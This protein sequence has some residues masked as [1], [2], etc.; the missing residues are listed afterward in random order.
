MGGRVPSI[1]VYNDRGEKIGNASSPTTSIAVAGQWIDINVEQEIKFQQPTFL[2]VDAVDGD[3]PS[4]TWVGHD[5]FNWDKEKITKTTTNTVTTIKMYMPE[6][7]NQADSGGFSVPADTSSLCRAPAMTFGRYSGNNS[8]F[9]SP[10]SRLRPTVF[11]TVFEVLSMII[12]AKASDLKYIPR[13]NNPPQVKVAFGG[14]LIS[15]H[16]AQHG[17]RDLC[18]DPFSLG[19]DFVSFSDSTFCDMETKTL[20]TLCNGET[21]I[22]RGCFDWKTKS[23]VPS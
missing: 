7:G 20:W 1:R 18:A 2:E 16:H 9:D 21:G 12:G 11:L 4:C 19:P 13:F 6:F 5:N 10:G 23:L 3:M 15:S 17:G 14:A 8:R 22:R